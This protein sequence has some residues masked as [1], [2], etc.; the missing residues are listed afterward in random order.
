MSEEELKTLLNEV[1]I[2]K[3]I[4]H[5]NIVTMFE[6]FEDEKRYYIV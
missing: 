5:P 1:N 2:L 6:F 4:D 3:E